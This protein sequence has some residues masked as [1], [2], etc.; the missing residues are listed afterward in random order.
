MVSDNPAVVSVP[1][2]VT[3]PVGATFTTVTFQTA[4]VAGPFAPKTVNVHAAYA[5]KTLTAAV[6]VV[7]PR[8]VS[9]TLSPDTVTAG[10]SSTAT[11]T[12]DRPSLNGSVVVDLVC[13]APG[14]ATV[15]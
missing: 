13:A 10:D 9:L 15:P 5:G 2:T 8:V 3:V 4:S 12:L 14:F 1:T 6:D 11:V 7:P